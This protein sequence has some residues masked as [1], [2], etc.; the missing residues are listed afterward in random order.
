VLFDKFLLRMMR[1][2]GGRDTEIAQKMLDCRNLTWPFIGRHTRVE[3]FY[4]YSHFL[5]ACHLGVEEIDHPSKMLEHRGRIGEWLGCRTLN[6]RVIGSNPSV[7]SV[8]RI[9]E[10]PRLGV[11]IIS[12]TACGTPTSVKKQNAGN[13]TT[14][15]ADETVKSHLDEGIDVDHQRLCSTNDELVHT[16]YRMWPETKWHNVRNFWNPGQIVP[17]QLVPRLF[18]IGLL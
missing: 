10:N 17:R 11:A 16:S 12:G 1:N 2:H 9:P 14:W 5:T 6:Q 13:V 4:K 18:I 8:S 3:I 7:V 15:K